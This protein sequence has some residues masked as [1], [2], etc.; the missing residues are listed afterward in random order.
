[1]RCIFLGPPGAGK[2]TQAAI[3]AAEWQVPHVSTGDMFRLMA[4]AE[5]PL[6]QD[7]R[8]YQ[9]RGELVPDHL[10]IQV[11]RQRLENTDV[12]KG[13][14]L[15]GFPRTVPQAEA[16]DALLGDLG[17]ICHWVVYFELPEDVLKARL[18]GRGRPDDTPD[19]I[20]TRLQVYQAQTAP[21]I[22]FYNHQQKLVKVQAD[23]PVET[24]TAHLR[25]LTPS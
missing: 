24:V 22:N 3:L 14:I 9:S 1:M 4:N 8:G 5:T 23:A 25:A 19:V 10:T 15:D 2:G 16:L 21:L 6:A 7:I 13:W 12:A 17:Q 11:V 20:E 18:L